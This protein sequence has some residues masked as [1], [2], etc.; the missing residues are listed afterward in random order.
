MRKLLSAIALAALAAAT[1]HADPPGGKGRGGGNGGGNGGG[2]AEAPGNGK[3]HGNG[4]GPGNGGGQPDRGPIMTVRPEHGNGR[5]ARGNPERGNPD[6]PVAI[7]RPVARDA[8][9]ELQHGKSADHRAMQ[10][11][12]QTRGRSNEPRDNFKHDTIV[13]EGAGAMPRTVWR[14]YDNRGL[15][16]GCPPGLAKKNN[17]CMP[18]GLAKQDSFARY[19]RNWWGL[20]GLND[21]SGYRYYDGSLVRLSPAGTIMSYYPLLGGALAIGNP[22]PNMWQPTPLAP[23][24]ADYYGLDDNYR[25]F[26]GA[27]YEVDPTTSA[28]QTIAALLTGDD[29]VVGQRI[30]LGYDIY[31][32]PYPYRDRYIDGPDAWYRYSDGYVYQIDPRTQLIVSAIQLL[33]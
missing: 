26:D 12:V 32:V 28:I 18:P 27:I 14:D 5:Q 15:V 33:T 25:Y 13:R 24:Y 2:A 30:P 22:W 1:V 20:R 19:D 6:R 29:F 23:Y 31:N 8:V 11:P 21:L 16:N 4:G 17:G 3:G 10:M 9:L 7:Q